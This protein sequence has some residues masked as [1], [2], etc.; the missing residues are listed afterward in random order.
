MNAYQGIPSDLKHIFKSLK[1]TL[2][3][4]NGAMSQALRSTSVCGEQSNR[5]INFY[6]NIIMTIYSSHI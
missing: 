1:I 3:W 2:N 5:K 6:V 4:N